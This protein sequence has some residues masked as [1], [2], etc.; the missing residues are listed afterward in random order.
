MK[1]SAYLFLWLVVFGILLS[2]AIRFLG[3]PVILEQSIQFAND[4]TASPEIKLLAQAAAAD[5]I[6]DFLGADS[7]SIHLK[8]Y[9]VMG[10]FSMSSIPI[11]FLLKKQNYSLFKSPVFYGILWIFFVFLSNIKTF[12]TAL[13]YPTTI[14]LLLCFMCFLRFFFRFFFPV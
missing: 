12:S 8:L 5:N 14:H 4:R 9:E 6:K 3:I 2:G 7:S 1:K 10:V 13:S 11:M